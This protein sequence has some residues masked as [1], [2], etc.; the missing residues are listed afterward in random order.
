M[1]FCSIYRKSREIHFDITKY[2][3]DET[4]NDTYY[5]HITVNKDIGLL[6]SSS[7]AAG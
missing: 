4:L 1:L 7:S 5:L 2:K 3:N 6:Y